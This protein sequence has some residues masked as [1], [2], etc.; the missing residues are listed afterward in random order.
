[1]APNSLQL[2]DMSVATRYRLYILGA[3][4]S[5]PYLAMIVWSAF[6]A[7]YKLRSVLALPASTPVNVAV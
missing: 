5:A 3:L 2:P 4:Y 1:M 7:A 6:N